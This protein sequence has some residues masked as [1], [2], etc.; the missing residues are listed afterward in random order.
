MINMLCFWVAG[1]HDTSATGRGGQESPHSGPTA[2]A[3]INLAEPRPRKTQVLLPSE[4]DA[5]ARNFL[6]N[7]NNTLAKSSLVI[8]YTEA[9]AY[10]EHEATF[11]CSIELCSILMCLTDGG[12]LLLLLLLLYC[13]RL[14]SFV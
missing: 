5:Q 2:S 10:G 4:T 12:F 9:G 14:A 1:R 3:P 8:V 7:Q 11:C 6:L 13:L